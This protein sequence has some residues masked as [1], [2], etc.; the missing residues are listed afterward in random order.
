MSKNGTYNGGSS[1][2][3]GSWMGRGKQPTNK[4]VKAESA[5][6]ARERGLP[7]GGAGWSQQRDAKKLEAE[8]AR[9]LQ[10]K[11]LE[12]IRIPTS[13]LAADIDTYKKLRDGK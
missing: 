9:K 8:E 5:E 2:M 1:L 7:L 6:I 10:I 4:M 13:A 3:R 12:K 11:K